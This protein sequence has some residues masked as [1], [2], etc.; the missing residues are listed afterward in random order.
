DTRRAERAHRV[1]AAVPAVE[2]ADDAHGR[3]VGRPDRER[4]AADSLDLTDVCAQ[5]PV[6]LLVPPLGDE[7]QV[8][9]ADRRQERIRIAPHESASV[10]VYRLDLVREAGGVA[11]DPHF[12]DP[13]ADVLELDPHREDPH[14]LRLRTQRAYDDAAV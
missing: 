10:R 11:L 1:E 4:G 14:R 13:A 5:L 7:V 6:Q 3:G 8:E 2:V 9:L 12:P